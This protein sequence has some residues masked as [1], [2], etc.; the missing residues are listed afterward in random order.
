MKRLASESLVYGLS[1]VLSKMIHIVLLPLYANMFSVSEYGILAI[2]TVFTSIIGQIVMLQLDSG[3]F[4]FIID[5]DNT[6][7]ISQTLS[8]WFWTQ[9]CLSIAVMLCSIFLK[10]QISSAL[11]SNSNYG[12]LIIVSMVNLPFSIA[13]TVCSTYW[14][15]TGQK[16]YVVILNVCGV[17][18][19]LVLNYYFIKY[20]KLGIISIAWS[21]LIVAILKSIALLPFIQKYINPTEFSIQRLKEMLKY[22]L[23]FVPAGISLWIVT[24]LDRIILEKFTNTSQVGI[25]Q[26]ANNIASLLTLPISA[27]LQAWSPYVFS[28]L[29]DNSHKQLIAN[30]VNW[31]TIGTCLIS[32]IITLFNSE[33]L[34]LL[35]STSYFISSAYVPILLFANVAMGL[36]QL[37][38]VG[39]AIAKKT[40]YIMWATL[41]SA[42]LNIILNFGLIPQFQIYGASWAK[43]ISYSIIPIYLFYYSNKVYAIPFDYKIIL[44][45]FFSFCILSLLSNNYM[46]NFNFNLLTLMLKIGGCLIGCLLIV[47][48]LKKKGLIFNKSQTS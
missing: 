14:R 18:L 24:L 48:Y 13:E 46:A 40:N 28:I 32:L 5:K 17:F 20:L 15:I 44:M 30:I 25:Y 1:G 19:L 37:S 43:L 47:F 42:A 4:R 36:Y 22:C 10:K 7:E 12:L 8:S 27:F 23:P 31:F 34:Y 3:A 21:S 39:S 16:W 33:I 9:F 2:L 26:M 41:I 45:T 29:S 38:G 35:S 11:F 6:S